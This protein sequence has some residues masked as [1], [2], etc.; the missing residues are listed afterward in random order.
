MR[1]LAI[2]LVVSA[3]CSRSP[4]EPG[5]AGAVQLV[6]KHQPLWGDP[7]PFHAFLDRFRRENPGIVLRTDTL[8]NGSD[9]AREM[10]VTALEGG[11]D[12]FDV[13]A[14]DVVWAPSSPE[15][16]GWRICRTLFRPLGCARNSCPARCRR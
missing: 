11:A 12:D 5:A 1:S 10:F 16:A 13:F 9:I 3:A 7:A 8:P 6:L 15:R 2:W 14:I 4:H